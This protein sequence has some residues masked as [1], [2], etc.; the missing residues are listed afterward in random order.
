MTG[1]AEL[2]RTSDAFL[3]RVERLHDLELRKRTL[4]PGTPEMI[5]LAKEI[6]DLSSE[7]LGWAKREADLAELAGKRQP[8]NIRPIAEVPPRAVPDILAEW[9]DAERT[10]DAQ[11]PGTPGWEAARVDVE[12]LRDE[13]R[14]ALEVRKAQPES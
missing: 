13:Y 6:E 3:S 14:R 2:R 8:T 11:T 12:S 9:R 7:V 10:F 4:T 5:Q 1:E